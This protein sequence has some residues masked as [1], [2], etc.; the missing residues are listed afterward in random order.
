MSNLTLSKLDLL[1]TVCSDKLEEIEETEIYINTNNCYR[2]FSSQGNSTNNSPKRE[3]FFKQKLNDIKSCKNIKDLKSYFLEFQEEFKK[4]PLTKNFE[5]CSTSCNLLRN[6]ER[7]LN[8][9]PVSI[10]GDGNCLFRSVSMVLYGNEGFHCELR[11]RC[12]IEMTLNFRNYLN[13]DILNS[14]LQKKLEKAD[15]EKIVYWLGLFC[16]SNI[17][18]NDE[19]I[20]E[21]EVLRLAQDG[22]SSWGSGWHF[23]GLA[24]CLNINIQQ[25]YPQI[26]DKLR[27][28]I[29]FDLFSSKILS[30]SPNF[31]ILTV[32]NDGINNEL[33]NVNDVEIVEETE[34]ETEDDSIF[35]DDFEKIVFEMKNK[36][37]CETRP[38]VVKKEACFLYDLNRF[39]LK[40]LV[41]D[42]KG[43]YNNLGNSIKFY[44]I[45]DNKELRNVYISSKK[46]PKAFEIT[47]TTYEIKR[48]Y[49]KLY[50]NPNFKRKIITMRNLK[51]P[52]NFYRSLIY[53]FWEINK[54]ISRHDLSFGIY[55]HG[56]ARKTAKPFIP[57]TFDTLE[58]IK[59]SVK[60]NTSKKL[61][62]AK[63]INSENNVNINDYPRNIKQFYNHGAIG[64]KNDFEK[65]GYLKTRY[66]YVDAIFNMKK[67]KLLVISFYSV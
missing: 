15:Q 51:N 24:N 22:L 55:S 54:E 50:S 41:K 45:N 42:G 67:R 11:F 40:N 9:I 56:N 43:R 36:T 61:E 8:F 12:I 32:M 39:C 60:K 19:K 65:K 35:E 66:S 4:Y 3:A 49:Y 59:Y 34:N 2:E 23:Y 57:S 53:Y 31:Y 7:N 37:L 44:N 62:Y 13:K 26:R 64:K 33:M 52:G 10:I 28:K 48:H 6:L 27:N 17:N 20:L 63:A 1:S 46:L 25:I 38:F 21:E 16:G 5:N 30:L 14:Q 18:C 47:E 58:D 29:Q